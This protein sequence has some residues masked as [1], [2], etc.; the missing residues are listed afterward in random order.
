MKTNY[1]IL[2]FTFIMNIFMALSLNSFVSSTV[3][4][5]ALFLYFISNLAAF[6]DKAYYYNTNGYRCEKIIS[7]STFLVCLF[8]VCI[9]IAH[10]LNLIEIVF[11]LEN[12]TYKI[13]MQGVQSAFFTFNSIDIT[14][15]TTLCVLLVPFSSFLLCI[16]PFLSS[17][18]YTKSCIL[19]ILMENKKIC[20]YNIIISVLMGPFGLLFC[21]IKSKLC[22]YGIGN[23]QYLKYFI[24]FPF[25]SFISLFFILIIWKKPK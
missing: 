15:I 9:Y 11:C 4:L 19:K 6:L 12:Q 17:H 13:L 18:G 21:F 14:I 10:T 20:I 7:F 5:P 2:F 24:S 8:P 23:P 1:K 25:F 22:S 16:I 3:F